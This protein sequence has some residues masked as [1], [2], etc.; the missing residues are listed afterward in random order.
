VS[1]PKREIKR[2]NQGSGHS[3]WIDG[4]RATGVTTALKALPKDLAR[5]G[6]RTVAEY[7]VQNPA[8]FA[9]MLRT[10]GPAPTVNFLQGLPYQ[11]RNDAAVR[12][13]AVHKLAEQVITGAEVEVPEHL[14][15]Y[16]QSYIRFLDEFGGNETNSELVVAN[17]THHY[18][19]TL[20][21]IQDISG[22][23]R[24]LVDYKTSNRIYGET[25]LQVAA[26]RFAEVCLIDGEEHSMPQ[27]DDTYVLHIQ[28]DGYALYP[29]KADEETFESFVAVL[30]VYRSLIQEVR[31]QK[32]MDALIGMPIEPP[33]RSAA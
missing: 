18:G 1:E 20:D 11:R 33:V 12:G 31:G 6:A 24:V 32:K 21:S 13:T 15:G 28:D 9:S 26:Y 17:R 14:V 27:V 2:S 10:G 3:Y 30:T 4:K 29:L 5:W 23:G 22:L 25:A 7:V 19:G 16:V 8:D